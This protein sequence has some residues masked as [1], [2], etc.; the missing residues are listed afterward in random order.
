MYGSVIWRP[1]N[2]RLIY[3]LRSKSYEASNPM[4]IYD[5]DYSPIKEELNV[6]RSIYVCTESKWYRPFPLSKPKK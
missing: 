4:H 3:E 1:N 2:Q 5:H 6:K